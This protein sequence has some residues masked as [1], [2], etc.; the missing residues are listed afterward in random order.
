[1][2][3][4]VTNRIAWSVVRSVMPV[5]P[6][7]T[8]EPIEML[9]GLRTRIGPENCALDGVQIP[10]WEAAIL[11]GTGRPIVKYMDTL[12]SSVQNGWTDQMP[13]GLWAR[14]GPKE[15]CIR[16]GPDPPWGK[17]HPLYSIG[18]I[19]CDLCE[20]GWTNR[21]GV[22]VVDFDGPKKAYWCNLANRTELSV[23]CSDAALC[24][25]TSTTCYY[26]MQTKTGFYLWQKW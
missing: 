4:I 8:A 2:R 19:C 20:K 11:R 6:A 5:S 24:Q 3:P 26:Y 17:E 1:M 23:C 15:S 10:L 14:D 21:F 22:C 16:W 7:K 13:F 12:W 25:I 18:T 9:F